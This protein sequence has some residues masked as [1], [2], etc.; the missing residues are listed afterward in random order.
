VTCQFHLVKETPKRRKVP[1]QAGKQ[2]RKKTSIPKYS[3]REK[4]PWL[5]ATS[6]QGDSARC[7]KKVIKIYQARMQIEESFR[8]L[9]TGLNFNEGDTRKLERLTILLLIAML[10][11]FVLYLF[12]LAVKLMNKHRSYQANSVKSKA[13]LSYQFIGL[14]AFKDRRFSVTSSDWEE[15]YLKLQQLMREV[16]LV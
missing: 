6:L 9:K 8:D 1:V 13:V 2:A 16:C 14:R 12:G 7:A 11:Q 5:L 15:T 4:E 10:A 3:Q